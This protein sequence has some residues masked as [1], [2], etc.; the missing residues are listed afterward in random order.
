MDRDQYVLVA[1]ALYSVP[2]RYVRCKLTTRADSSTVRLYEGRVLVKVHGRVAPGQRATDVNDFPEA[3]RIYAHR[4]VDT[5]KRKACEIGPC[6]GELAERI[7]DDPRPWTRMRR[8]YALVGLAR[9]Y[10]TERLEAACRLALQA[11]MLDVVRLRRLLERG[12]RP[13][14]PRIPAQV[15][16]IARYLRPH[17]HFALRREQ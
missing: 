13:D 5:L 1:K 11:D 9:K 8:V 6:T 16:P 3:T 15:I 4:D 17:D 10:G 12:L 7:L 2:T 14:E